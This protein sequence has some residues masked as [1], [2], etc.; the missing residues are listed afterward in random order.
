MEERTTMI[1]PAPWPLYDTKKVARWLEKMARQGLVLTERGF[2]GTLPLAIFQRTNRQNLRYCLV[3]TVSN[4]YAPEWETIAWNEARGWMYVARYG[5]YYV[6]RSEEL[7]IEDLET[8]PTVLDTLMGRW[9]IVGCVIGLILFLALTATVSSLRDFL[10]FD[11]LLAF[12]MMV[13][14]PVYAWFAAR[15]LKGW[16]ERGE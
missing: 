1:R 2:P 9:G 14:V 3:G 12:A 6:Y 15:Y 10:K 13:G 8:A 11:A 5:D 7:M 4:A 16:R